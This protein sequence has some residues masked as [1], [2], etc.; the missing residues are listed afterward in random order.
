M[1][2]YMI[3]L[4]IIISMSLSACGASNNEPSTTEPQASP[5][6]L[7]P[8]ISTAECT[9]QSVEPEDLAQPG[10]WITGATEGYAVTMIEYADFQ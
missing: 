6:A 10:D 9:A 3:P 8:L 2:K 5:T 1:K 4:I 7:P